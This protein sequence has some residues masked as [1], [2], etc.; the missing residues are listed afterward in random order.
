[1]DKDRK[2]WFR[3]RV[4][5]A[6]LVVLALV[7][8]GCG[9]DDDDE[10]A[11]TDDTGEAPAGEECGSVVVGSTNFSE[12]FI[13]AS[14]YAQKLEAEGCDVEVRANLGTREVVFPALEEGEI[15]LVAEYVG[16]L[17]EFLNEGAGEATGDLEESLGILRGYLEERGLAALEPSDAQDRNALAVTQETAE[18]YG[19]ETVSD[20][21]DVAGELVLGG[22]PEC[23]ERPLC[24]PGYE[25]V[26]GL[27]FA[28]F[29]PL[30][31]GG[32]LT[33]EALENGDIDV[34]LVFSSQGQLVDLGLVVL[35]EDQDLQPAEN[36]LPVVR[37]D[38][39]NDTVEAALDEVSA[40]LTTEELSELNKRV[41]VDKEDPEDVARDWL[42]EKG[43]V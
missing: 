19:L 1:M 40:Q 13:V 30:D 4:Y 23:P 5:T 18:R 25:E 41:D 37:Q 15:D 36:I 11:A 26:Y 29:R 27:Q 12:Q 14:M 35:E 33:F 28:E 3:G 39:L 7:A 42:E 24:L 32:P 16:T 31:A 21:A 20:L 9:G 2:W 8:V 22:P 6:F 43:L 38:V 10:E 34:A 17:V